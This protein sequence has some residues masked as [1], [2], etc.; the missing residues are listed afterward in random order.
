MM[1]RQDSGDPGVYNQKVPTCILLTP[2]GS[3]HSFGYAA[4]E[5][6]RDLDE[7]EAV[8]W[9]FFDRFKMMLYEEQVCSVYN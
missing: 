9:M 1:R 2:E 8:N 4:S 3:F 6:Y 5:Y 7:K